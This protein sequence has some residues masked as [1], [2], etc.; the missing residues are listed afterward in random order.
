VI[1]WGHFQPFHNGHCDAL[2]QI[3]AMD[4]PFHRIFFAVASSE[5]TNIRDNP[6]SFDERSA[7]IRAYMNSAEGKQLQESKANTTYDIVPITDLADQEKYAAH[8]CACI[9][10]K[11]GVEITGANSVVVC[12][13]DSYI[14]GCFEPMFQLVDVRK[15]IDVNSGQ[16][17]E[18]MQRDL[19]WQYFVNAHAASVIK[20]IG[21]ARRCS[22]I[23]GRVRRNP[24]PTADII[25]EA[26]CADGKTKG[27]VLIRRKNKPYGWALPGGFVEYGEDVW[28][29]ARR[30]AQEETSAVCKRLYLLGV[31]GQPDRDPRSHTQTS[32]F[33]ARFEDMEGE[34]YV[35][36]DDAA[37][38]QVFPLDALPEPIVFDHPRIIADYKRMKETGV[39]PFAV[40]EFK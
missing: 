25:M 35:G 5:H 31:Y 12:G 28:D 3:Y 7:M 17:R 24:A 32:A 10:E 29:S 2:K 36:G 23:M 18:M 26:L 20:E 16:I 1:F 38:A 13:A 37:E 30:E 40:R 9:K 33:V 27:I 19:P 14:R 8:V 11:T 21:G 39:W 6:F 34:K 22:V 15:N 4:I